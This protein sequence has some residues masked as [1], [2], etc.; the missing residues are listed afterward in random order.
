[1]EVQ[2]TSCDSDLLWYANEIGKTYE[3][4]AETHLPEWPKN[5]K[6]KAKRPAYYVKKTGQHGGYLI[7]QNHCKIIENE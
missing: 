5:N 3:V 4:I 6:T 7:F 1:M 2:V